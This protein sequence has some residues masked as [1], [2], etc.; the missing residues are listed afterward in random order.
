MKKL[1]S[2]S[3]LLILIVFSFS[4]FQKNKESNTNNNKIKSISI[5]TYGG[6]M[7]YSQS[8]KLTKDSLHF[9]FNIAVDSTR[10]RNEKKL[11]K[12]YKLDDIVSLAE[13]MSFS[14]IVDGKSRLPVD[15]TDTKII[16]E[17]GEKEYSIINGD[18]NEIWRRIEVEMASIINKEFKTK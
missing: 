8:L 1:F 15:G 11:N 12:L 6:E 17:T 9:S 18:N 3:I 16:I 4:C 14:K 7:G 2:I 5:L 13:A 10:K